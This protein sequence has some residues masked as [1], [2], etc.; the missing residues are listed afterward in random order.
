MND[1]REEA[2][3][4]DGLGDG[5]AR[6]NTEGNPPYDVDAAARRI[7]IETTA[8]PALVLDL[9]CGRGR[10][11][12]S[13]ARLLPEWTLYG[14]DV[15]RRLLADAKADAVKRRVFNV[16]YRVGD[17]RT[18]PPGDPFDLVYSIAMFQHI[19]HDAMWGYIR[20]VHDRLADGGKFVF[21][22]AEGEIDE[23]LN[24]QIADVEA[25][26]S[27]LADMWKDVMIERQ[28][29]NDWTWVTVTK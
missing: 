9:G 29:L 26:G 13:I 16:H 15:S 22:I 19:P 1:P 18:L 20:Q 24:H 25:F 27:E 3:W 4:W 5:E 17:G 14:T 2:A 6:L 23:F 28:G 11:T 7:L 12:N 10:L 21:T 8:H